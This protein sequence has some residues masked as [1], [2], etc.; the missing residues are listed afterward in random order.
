MKLLIV[1]D[2]EMNQI[3]LEE[4]IQ[5]LF[6]DVSIDV[7][8]SAI[9]ALAAGG[10]EHYGLILTDIDMPGMDGMEFYDKLR[11]DV[12]GVSVPIIAIT[13]LAVSGDKEKLLM[14]GF[15]NYIS[16]PID[17]GNLQDTLTPLLG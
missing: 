3:V 15:D 17:L 4:M 12:Y 6:P 10:L 9:D 11:S 16:K 13:A 8:S 5:I 1:D 14:H 7:Q 2:N